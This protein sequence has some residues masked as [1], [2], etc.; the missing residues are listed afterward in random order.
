MARRSQRGK[1]LDARLRQ[2]TRVHRNLNMHHLLHLQLPDGR[3]EIS[4]TVTSSAR[5]GALSSCPWLQEHEAF[6]HAQRSRRREGGQERYAP[7]LVM[8]PR[9]PELILGALIPFLLHETQL[10][11]KPEGLF[12]PYAHMSADRHL[13]FHVHSP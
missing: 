8:H 13:F 10:R 5:T 9:P 12:S 4:R 7:R 2:G 6:V 11:G 1:N 3:K